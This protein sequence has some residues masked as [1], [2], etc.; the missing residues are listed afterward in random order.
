[1]NGQQEPPG[2]KVVHI[3]FWLV[4][5]IFLIA[6]AW[7][8]GLYVL[9]AYYAPI[10]N[11]SLLDVDSQDD[12]T[13]IYAASHTLPLI[14]C[15]LGLS[16]FT[17]SWIGLLS[18]RAGFFLIAAGVSLMLFLFWSSSW[19]WSYLFIWGDGW[20]G[21]GCEYY[22]GSGG[23][24]TRSGCLEGIILMVLCLIDFVLNYDAFRRRKNVDSAEHQRILSQYPQYSK[25]V[26][27]R[28]PQSEYASYEE[29]Y[30]P[31]VENQGLPHTP[32]S[33]Y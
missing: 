11:Q 13:C 12:P 10:W 25:Q 8:S 1:M 26:S 23:T 32:P 4:R 27:Y 17:F 18:R 7:M 21:T 31:Y 20:S 15:L 19:F 9:V 6:T 22:L 29:E 14:C 5:A 28:Q 2:N 30:V 33:A 24:P 16:I 3:I